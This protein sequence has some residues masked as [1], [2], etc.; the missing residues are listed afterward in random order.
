MS[1]RIWCSCSTSRSRSGSRAPNGGAWGRRTAR[2][3]RPRR[4]AKAPAADRF[5]REDLAFFRRVREVYLERV[6]RQPE[7]YAVIDAGADADTVTE[8]IV[9]EVS[10]RLP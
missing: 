4:G 3:D 10:E 7:R 1:A 9:R 2:T 5:E 6:R 8:R